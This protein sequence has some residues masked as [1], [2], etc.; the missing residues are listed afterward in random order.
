[1]G[2]AANTISIPILR[3]KDLYTSTFN[4]LLIVLAVIDNAYLILALFESARNEMG[5]ATDVH[6]AAFAF[7][8]YP[9]H[10]IM[11]CLSIYMTVVLAMERHRAVSKPIDY[12]TIIVS[13][14]QWQRVFHYVGPVLAFSVVFNL[15]KFFELKAEAIMENNATENRLN[16]S[17]TA[18]AFSPL[19]CFK[20]LTTM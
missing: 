15:P 5:L 18:Q 1:M 17:K 4:R 14:R 11:L 2:L 19:E 20:I 16:V 7:A 3:A 8:L 6:T 10:N 13:G 9:L 12:H